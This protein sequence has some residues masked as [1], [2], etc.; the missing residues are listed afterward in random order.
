MNQNPCAFL[1]SLCLAAPAIARD[2]PIT[3]G[4]D[5]QLMFD[6]SLIASA[7]GVALTQHEPVSGGIALKSD[8][9]WDGDVLYMSSLYR[10]NGNFHLL[11]RAI[12]KLCL[13]VSADGVHWDK[14]NLGLVPFNGSKDNNIVTDGRGRKIGMG[15]SFFDPRPA[16]PENERVKVLIWSDG[17]RYYH[18]PLDNQAGAKPLSVEW[19]KGVRTV[20]LGSTD[21][22]AFHEVPLHANLTSRL[23]NSYDGGSIFWSETEQQFVGYFRWWDEHPEPHARLLEDR[24]IITGVGVRSVFRSTSKDLQTWSDPVPMTYGNSPREHLYENATFPYFRAPKLY[25]ALANRFNPGRRALSSDEETGLKIRGAPA[26]KGTPAFSFGSDVNDIVLMVTKPGAKGYARPF[27]EAFMRPGAN[28][29]NWSSR[30]NYPNLHGGVFQTG[31]AEMSFLVTRQHFQKDNHIE[32]MVLRVDGFASM[33]A[34][35]AGGEF[36]TTSVVFRGQRLEL[37][38]ATS[39]AGDIRV[40]IQNA[41]GRPLPGYALADCDLLIGDRIDG[42]VR[43]RGRT[44]VPTP[45]QPIRLRF[46]MAD[47]DIYS[48]RFAE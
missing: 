22:R 38:Y 17:E 7:K 9:P 34:P 39:G 33:K 13:A 43:W 48:F 1:L 12:D 19:R 15:F 46:Q 40:E 4:S 45:G 8:R 44:A 27:M 20:L 26:T 29:G 23:P 3:I 31:P 47:A 35:Y 42:V 21:G 32:R 5:R 30:C 24:G 25:V 14:P 16:V 11:Y 36:V 6:A 28:P 37:N 41:D 10:V 18:Y 2:T